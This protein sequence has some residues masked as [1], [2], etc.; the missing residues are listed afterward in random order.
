M[1]WKLVHGDV[2]R[3]PKHLLALSALIGSGI[4]M[5]FAFTGTILFSVVGFLNPSYRGGLL[6]YALFFFAFSG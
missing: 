1:G 3:P 6:Q 2:F 4:Q 5:F